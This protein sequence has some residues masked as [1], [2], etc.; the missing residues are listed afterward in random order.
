[1]L[2]TFAVLAASVSL[3]GSIR[4]IVAAPV[5]PKL[6]LPGAGL[7]SSVRRRILPSGWSGSWAGVKRWRSPTVR[8]RYWPSGE[9]ATC[10]P[11]WPPLPLGHLAPQHL[12]VFQSRRGGG[13]VQLRAG[14][15][16]AAAVVTRLGIGEIDALVGGVMGRDEHAV[17]AVLA[18][19][20]DGGRVAH[21][22]I[23]CPCGD[24]SQTGPTFSVISMRPSGRKASRHGSSKVLTVVMVK[25]RL[26]SGFCSPTLTWARIAAAARVTSNAAFANFIVISPYLTPCVSNSRPRASEPGFCSVPHHLGIG[27]ET[28][29]PVPRS[30]IQIVS[31]AGSTAV[32]VLSPSL[33]TVT[34]ALSPV[35]V[36]TEI[37]PLPFSARR[38]VPLAHIPGH[39]LG[40]P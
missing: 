8:N 14:Q 17:H 1:M 12:E 9:K 19:P 36:I 22:A 20:V 16:Q 24:T 3:G 32:G 28:A 21:R 37:L 11:S 2:T 26:A 29:L 40:I 6:G 38:S 23:F 34:L 31:P 7:P 25:G 13:G 10:A 15:R 27:I 33:M 35:T 30:A 18:L 5:L 4:G 39:H